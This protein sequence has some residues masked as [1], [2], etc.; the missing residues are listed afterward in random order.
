MRLPQWKKVEKSAPLLQPHIVAWT[1]ATLVLCSLATGFGA[2]LVCNVFGYALPAHA[3]MKL[4]RR[5]TASSSE[6][7]SNERAQLEQWISYW[8][9]FAAF[10]VVE[11]IPSLIALLSPLYYPGKFLVLCYCHELSADA[12]GAR[13]VRA[14]LL[15]LFGAAPAP[16]V[17]DEKEAHPHAQ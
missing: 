5:V 11:S 17:V 13:V 1:L 3:S 7:I 10:V 16:G 14:K 6:P 15:S 12:S 9:I 8:I 2:K 4:V